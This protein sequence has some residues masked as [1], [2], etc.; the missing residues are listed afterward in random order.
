MNESLRF[1]AFSGLLDAI[2]CGG[3]TSPDKQRA[4]PA[5]SISFLGA[6][7]IATVAV[8]VP[9]TVHVMDA[10]GLAVAG[11][12]VN[13]VV[14]SGGGHVFAGTASTSASGDAKEVWTL[15]TVAGPQRLEA[16]AVDQVTGQPLTLA[17]L[18]TSAQPGPA[19]NVR[20]SLLQPAF[21]DHQS[22]DLFD[23]NAPGGFGVV[24]QYGNYIPNYPL[25]TTVA[26]AQ[27][28]A[29]NG[30]VLAPNA[31]NLSTTATVNVPN[32]ESHTFP[33]VSILNLNL[34]Q[35]HISYTCGI[36]D[37]NSAIV[38][39]EWTDPQ[40]GIH[41]NSVFPD[42]MRFSGT[43]DSVTYENSV[44]NSGRPGVIWYT[45]TWHAWVGTLPNA[46][47][48]AGGPAV[49]GEADSPNN[50]TATERMAVA[51]DSVFLFPP[52]SAYRTN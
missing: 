46:S 38:M 36:K 20:W 40:T 17:S 5:A 44:Y 16:R 14:A 12:L 49:T 48:N 29:V 21:V 27:H 6:P 11:Q 41:Y 3:A 39:I 32:V 4:G 23:R 15:G 7:A 2:A 24:D 25:T 1:V 45:A 34:H 19:A 22:R 26:D 37:R 35:W 18:D 9:V 47:G 10:S 13:F 31:P 8:D 51:P 50:F 30:T 43:V 52:T 42:S 33:V 28:W